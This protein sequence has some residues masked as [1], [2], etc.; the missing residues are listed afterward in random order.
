MP[1]AWAATAYPLRD[2][3]VDRPVTSPERRRDRIHAYA[4]VRSIV[5]HKPTAPIDRDSGMTRK[6]R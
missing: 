1:R 5:H 3:A 2:D 6:R 4:N